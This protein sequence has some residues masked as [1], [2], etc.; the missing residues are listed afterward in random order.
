MRWVVLT[1]VVALVAMLLFSGAVRPHVSANAAKLQRLVSPGE[2]SAGHAFLENRCSACHTQGRGVEAAN[3]IICHANN[4]NLLQRQPTEFHSSISRC[5]ECHVEHS[6]R[7]IR[8]VA[9]DHD[10]LA[11][12]GLNALSREGS[13]SEASLVA[14][15]LRNWIGSKPALKSGAPRLEASLDCARCHGTKDRH[16]GLFG[17]ECSQCHVTTGWKVAGF[18]HPSS[19]SFDCVQCHQAPPS[20]YMEHFRMVSMPVAGVESAQVNECFVCHQ[21]TSWND[22]RRV[23]WYKHH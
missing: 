18:R 8:S 4:Q 6:G 17:N 13:G 20:H 2:L 19:E 14:Q 7:S 22:I 15:R 16:V 10:A 11:R 1:A 23:G 12:I 21:T 3:C 5:A 9:M